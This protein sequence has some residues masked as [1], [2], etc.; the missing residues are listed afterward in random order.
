M[1]FLGQETAKIYHKGV[2]IGKAY[3]SGSL[4]FDNSMHAITQAVLTYATGQGYTP[5]SDL[6]A[7]DAHI[8]AIEGVLAKKDLY[9]I[10]CAD[11]STGFKLINIVNPG[12]FNGT[13]FGGLTWLN[14][15]VQGNGTNAYISTGF[16]PSLLATGQK[17]QLNAASRGATV[18]AN[19][20]P[21]G[22]DSTI[23]GAGSLANTMFATSSNGNKINQ[24]SGNASVTS[25]L[26][27]TGL[28]AIVRIGASATTIYNKAATTTSTAASTNLPITQFILTRENAGVFAY[29]KLTLSSYFMGGSLTGTDISTIRTAT[30]NYLTAVGLSAVA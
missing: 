27:G 19:P 23:D 10:F 14:S 22:T 21:T 5:P 8:R 30:N 25:D 4:V 28:K 3:R 6:S 29:S 1:Y 17:Y 11:G 24:S 20:S 7:Y 18:Y 2:E 15:G 9:Y 26:S 12:T 13:G 16:N